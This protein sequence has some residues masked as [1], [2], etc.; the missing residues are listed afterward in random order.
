MPISAPAEPE[1]LGGSAGWDGVEE[2]SLSRSQDRVI[3]KS[4][5]PPCYNK[6]SFR[7]LGQNMPNADPAHHVTPAVGRDSS[8]AAIKASGLSPPVS[9][10]V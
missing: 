10:Y 8:R 3:S 9:P 2:R 6:T 1:S 7:P 5:P 4:P